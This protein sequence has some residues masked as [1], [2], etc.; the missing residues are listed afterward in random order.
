VGSHPETDLKSAGS[1]KWIVTAK[2]IVDNLR[3][4]EGCQAPISSKFRPTLGVSRFLDPTNGVGQE[5]WG[6]R[7]RQDT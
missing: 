7:G 3:F 6:S 2:A 5:K 1:S 4:L